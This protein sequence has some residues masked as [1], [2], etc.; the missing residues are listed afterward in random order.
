M[1]H[2][3]KSKIWAYKMLYN[4]FPDTGE[5]MVGI[6]LK[7]QD[8]LNNQS[9]EWRDP[10]EPE[11]C[12]F[13]KVVIKN[14]RCDRFIKFL[15]NIGALKLILPSLED[16][17]LVP[18]DKGRLRVCNALDHTA[19]VMRY[20]HEYAEI[21][22]FAAIFHDIGK[23]DSVGSGFQ[24]HERLSAVRAFNIVY[25][26]YEWNMQSAS[27]LFHI[28]NNHKLPHDIQRENRITDSDLPKL[29]K[30]CHGLQNV[31]YTTQLCIADKRA[32]HNR[33]DFLWA[34]YKILE[35]VEVYWDA[36]MHEREVEVD[37]YI[38]PI[39]AQDGETYILGRVFVPGQNEREYYC[40]E[41]RTTFHEEAGRLE[42]YNFIVTH[43][44]AEVNV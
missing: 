28:I 30:R 27:R 36:G 14:P 4:E 17:S 38:C 11:I 23:Y 19:L 37:R 7:L 22:R 42:P 16:L 15:H 29:K 32:S 3:S 21:V 26:D 6:T 41:C 44:E 43:A 33:K 25:N 20:A 5:P 31:W 18:Q 8:I 12:D 34:Y 1:A 40:S 9:N 39:C 10:T 35:L 13:L 24:D 2:L